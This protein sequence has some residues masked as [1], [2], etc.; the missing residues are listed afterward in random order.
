M[1][2]IFFA[3]ALLPVSAMAVTTYELAPVEMVEPLQEQIRTQGQCRTI[4]ETVTPHGAGQPSSGVGGSIVGGIVGGLLGN[5]VGGGSGKDVA[6]AAGA[7]AGAIVGGNMDRNSAGGQASSTT[8]QVCDPD[9]ITTRT[10]GYRVTYNYKGYRETITM[11]SHPGNNIE[12]R[13]TAE[14]VAR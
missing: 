1:K 13:V 6:T 10:R 11:P 8:R 5:Q 7:I 12:L 9:T 3:L 4:T 2:K 14:P